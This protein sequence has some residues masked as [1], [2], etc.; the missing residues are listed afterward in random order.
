MNVVRVC[1]WYWI[2]F[3]FENHSWQWSDFCVG[4]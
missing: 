1:K 2:T 3:E 4:I